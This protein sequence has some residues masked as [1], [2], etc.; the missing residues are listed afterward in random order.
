[1]P[2][3]TSPELVI[4]ASGASARLSGLGLTFVHGRTTWQVPVAAIR[5][6]ETTA[7][8]A[9]VRVR[10]RAGVSLP[11]GTDPLLFL[12]AQNAHAA[13]AFRAGVAGAV[14]AAPPVDAAE[15][16]VTVVTRP[17]RLDRIRAAAD[18]RR[19]LYGT[20]WLV[21]FAVVLT[22]TLRAE[23]PWVTAV[24]SF[25][26]LWIA[27]LGCR[28]LFMGIPARSR[29]RRPRF[30]RRLRR[31]GITVGGRITGYRSARYDSQYFPL[32]DFTTADAQELQGVVS[33]QV[34]WE[35]ERTPGF[36][37]VVYDPEEPV[38]ASVTGPREGLGAFAVVLGLI[39]LAVSVGM[40]VG[41]AAGGG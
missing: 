2:E 38:L 32:L 37:L 8:P 41:G 36:T 39:M 12:P 9:G 30:L 21:W 5:A 20:A 35:K 7:S 40:L 17:S 28:I 25:Q 19:L 10:F 6:A 16:L 11:E 24:L 29:P 33:L 3:N 13:E 18:R 22:V 34:V 1:M 23:S 27:P 15:V 31:N 26:S 4:A 14:A